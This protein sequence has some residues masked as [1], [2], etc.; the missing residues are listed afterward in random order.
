MAA[1][2]IAVPELPDANGTLQATDKVVCVSG[3]STSNGVTSLVSVQLLP[4][5]VSTS[6]GTPVNSIATTVKSGLMWT[7]GNYLY[8]TVANNTVKRTA[9][10]TF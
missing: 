9:L 1:Q 2:E 6:L 4:V 8:V 3:L 10:S 5:Y 7:D